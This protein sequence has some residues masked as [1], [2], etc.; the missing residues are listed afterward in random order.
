MWPDVCVVICEHNV[1][2]VTVSGMWGT[3]KMRKSGKFVSE[4]T[5]SLNTMKS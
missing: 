5:Y 2:G 4:M 1:P 3:V